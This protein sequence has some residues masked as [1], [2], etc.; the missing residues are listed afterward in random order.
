M[1]TKYDLAKT[2]LELTQGQ[3]DKYDDFSAKIKT[4]AIT[5]WAALLGWSFQSQKKEVLLLA[6][7]IIVFFW[8]FDAINKNFRQN[9][10]A[11]RDE[12][13]KALEIVFRTEQWPTDF[14]C[15]ALPPHKDIRILRQIFRIHIAILYLPLAIIALILF[16]MM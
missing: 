12:I 4:W 14:I 16:V 5:S 13:A 1:E 9:Y 6:L 8:V 10:K 7:L 11:R 2:E 3:M 15:P